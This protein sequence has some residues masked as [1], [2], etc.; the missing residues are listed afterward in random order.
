MC[1][2]PFVK[3]LKCSTLCLLPYKLYNIYEQLGIDTQWLEQSV[4]RSF[5]SAIASFASVHFILNEWGLLRIRWTCNICCIYGNTI[6]TSWAVRDDVTIKTAYKIS[7]TYWLLS[8]C[9]ATINIFILWG[10]KESWKV[11]FVRKWW[12]YLLIF[13]WST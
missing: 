4:S 11:I 5:F 13:C 6:R 2:T 3:D 10:I 7:G 12:I 9:L 1:S 8:R